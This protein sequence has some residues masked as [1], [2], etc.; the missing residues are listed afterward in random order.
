[1]ISAARR[2]ETCLR[3]SDTIIPPG[4]E[5]LAARLKGDEFTI[6][7]E[8]LH[9]VGEAKAVAERLLKEISAPFQVDGHEVFLSASIGIALSP[10]GYTCAEEVLRDADVAMYRAKSLGRARCE[11][12][13]TVIIESAQ[14]RLQLEND[15][16]KAAGSEEIQVVS[17]APPPPLQAATH[18]PTPPVS[19]QKPAATKAQ[20]ALKRVVV[21]TRQAPVPVATAITVAVIHDHRL[22]SC[23]GSL[24]VTQEGIS[25]VPEKGKDG[26][27]LNYAECSSALTNDQLTIKSGKKIW[28][29]KSASSRSKDENRADLE[30]VNHFMTKKP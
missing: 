18:A 13:D 25:F 21:K 30:R 6:L 15:L 7:L 27:S 20:P 9:E 8:G 11:F 24:L 12:F 4:R 29:F 16:G 14:T 28:H 17:P 10:T 5:H 19:V 2:I 22:G 23:K 3:T 1:L 26:F